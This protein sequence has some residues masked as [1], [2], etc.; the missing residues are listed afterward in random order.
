MYKIIQNILIQLKRI[1]RPYNADVIVDFIFVK[2]LFFISIKNPGNKPAYRVSIN[3]NDKI[4]GLEGT[5]EISELP[6]FKNIEFLAPQKE[7][8][9][10]LDTSSSYFKRENP[11]QVVA[12]IT[13]HDGNGIEYNKIIKH[14]LG[15]YK[16]IGY[17]AT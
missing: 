14:D 16:E 1:F 7:I 10:F 11:I 5:K 8:K 17:I 2:G 6:L 12:N 13:Y 3:F 9:T 15:I 4:F